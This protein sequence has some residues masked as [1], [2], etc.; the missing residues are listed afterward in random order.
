MNVAEVT[1]NWRDTCCFVWVTQRLSHVPKKIQRWW[2]HE[3]KTMLAK[4]FSRPS[5]FGLYVKHNNSLIFYDYF[6]KLICQVSVFESTQKDFKS[7]RKLM[8]WCPSKCENFSVKQ[9]GIFVDNS[10]SQ[11][12]EISGKSQ[13]ARLPSHQFVP[14]PA[15]GVPTVRPD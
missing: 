6:M 3:A 10:R 11:T 15:N 13:R 5:L 2:Q 1:V 14:L 12:P 7:Y 4:A 8:L 9:T